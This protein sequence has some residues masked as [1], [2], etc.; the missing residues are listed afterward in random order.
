MWSINYA[1]NNDGIVIERLNGETIILN[2]KSGT[3]YSSQGPGSDLIWLIS[4]KISKDSWKQILEQHYIFNIN[5]KDG[6]EEF[7]QVA[8]KE[9]LIYEIENLDS[10]IAELPLDCERSHWVMPAL[11]KHEEI[12]HLLL[13]DP[14][15][16]SAIEGWPN[17]DENEK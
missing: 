5:Q 1:I 17:L 14:I 6:I 3:Y 2:F 9:N 12:E 4:N 8:L 13:V 10:K 15:H 7:L 16:D 11:E